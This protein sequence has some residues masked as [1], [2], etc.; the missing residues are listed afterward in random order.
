MCGASVFTLTSRTNRSQGSIPW[1]THSLFYAP[2]PGRTSV[3]DVS[4]QPGKRAGAPAGFDAAR[5]PP[6]SNAALE[7]MF[8]PPSHQELRF[9]ISAAIATFLEPPGGRR[10]ELHRQVKRLYDARSATVHGGD[11]LEFRSLCETYQ[12]LRRSLRKMI[13]TRAV[14]TQEQLEAGLLC[15][16]EYVTLEGQ[17][18]P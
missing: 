2:G 13:E 7:R 9:R 12:L 5:R 8:S 15:G 17:I 6:A 3:G 1:S 18:R 4:T 11:E 14:P 16:S 10:H